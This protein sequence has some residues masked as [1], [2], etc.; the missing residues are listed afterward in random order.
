MQEL[1]VVSGLRKRGLK[2]TDPAQIEA[3]PSSSTLTL[4]ECFLR[5]MAHAKHFHAVFLFLIFIYLKETAIAR[6]SMNGKEREKQ[7]PR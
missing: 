7:T 1:A 2:P 4:S 5:V 6:E 3:R